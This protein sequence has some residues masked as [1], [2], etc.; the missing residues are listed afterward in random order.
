M[1]KAFIFIGG[2]VTGIV[3]TFLLAFIISSNK[4][5]NGCVLFEQEG[6]VISTNSFEVF[7]VLDSGD[8]LATESGYSGLIVLFLNEDGA[9]YY[10]D[11]EIEVPMES[12]SN[13]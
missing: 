1:R 7:H 12:A 6:K 11:Q 9:S 2:V 4:V 13:S 5:N 10:D 8:A 3:L